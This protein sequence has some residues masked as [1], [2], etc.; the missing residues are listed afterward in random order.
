MLGDDLDRMDDERLDLVKKTLP[1]PREVAVPINLFACVH[2]ATPRVFHRHI[3]KAWGSFD[4]VAV[5]NFSDDLLRES[6]SMADLQLDPVKR[7]L[8]FEFWNGEYQGRI[9]GQLVAVVPPRSVRVYRLTEDTHAPTLM[10]TDMHLLM[11]EMEILDCA[12]DPS[13]MTLSGRVIRPAGERGSLFIHAPETVRVTTP[14]GVSIAKDARDMTLIIRVP[15][16]FGVEGGGIE[17]FRI[18]FAPL[19]APQKLDTRHDQG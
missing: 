10:G 9:T 12:W 8:V 5:Y 11:G 1:R 17:S 14:R 15:L 19:S 3:V 4:V 2:P 7:H 16:R 6:V 13:A 18:G